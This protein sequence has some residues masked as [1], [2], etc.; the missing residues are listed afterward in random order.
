MLG[1][2]EPPPKGFPKS[3]IPL[4]Q[5]TTRRSTTGEMQWQKMHST[6]AEA[7]I[8]SIV[9]VMQKMLINCEKIFVL[10]MRELRL[11]VRNAIILL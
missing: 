6:G 8:S 1:V 7:R 2:L 11:S 10:S 4:T 3:R 9:C 5:V